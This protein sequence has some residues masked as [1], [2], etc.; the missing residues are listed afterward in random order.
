MFLNVNFW[1]FATVVAL[2]NLKVPSKFWV[3]R[4][5]PSSPNKKWRTTNKPKKSVAKNASYL[6]VLEN[7]KEHVFCQWQL[8]VLPMTFLG[9]WPNAR[10]WSHR[11]G[12]G[13]AQPFEF[14]VAELH[15]V[16]WNLA[17]WWRFQGKVPENKT[18][19]SSFEGWAV[20]CFPTSKSFL[21]EVNIRGVFFL[22]SL[23][24]KDE[25]NIG[26]Y[27]YQKF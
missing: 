26:I 13:K 14:P 11:T 1:K 4:S 7:K 9:G 18:F 10:Q 5:T 12:Q 21:G 22:T 3:E 27:W 23:W 20:W 25:Q 17:V 19:F 6:E 2:G 24:G 15:G 16:P 8:L